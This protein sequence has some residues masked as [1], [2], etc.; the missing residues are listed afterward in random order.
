MKRQL[1][2]LPVLSIA[3]PAGAHTNEYL[4]TIDGARTAATQGHVSSPLSQPPHLG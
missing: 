3:V 4:D 1:L 2:L